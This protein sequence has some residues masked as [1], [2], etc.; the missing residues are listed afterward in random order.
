MLQAARVPQPVSARPPRRACTPS[1][2]VVPP[3]ARERFLPIRL[4]AEVT[5]VGVDVVRAVKGGM[6]TESVTALLDAGEFRW[7]WDVSRAGTH[8][9]ELRFLAAEILRQSP[10]RDESSA[11]VAALGGMERR[12]RFRCAEVEQRWLLSAQTVLRLGRAEE[13][14]TTMEGRTKWISRDSLVAFLQRRLI[15]Q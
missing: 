12:P 11:I 1:A 9:R 8:R 2:P 7:V 5:L 15:R 14:R 10:P 3:E 4:G 13:F 6:D